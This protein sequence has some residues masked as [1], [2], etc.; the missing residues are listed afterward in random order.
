MEPLPEYVSDGVIFGSG[1]G[2]GGSAPF[3]PKPILIELEEACYIGSIIPDSLANL[4][5]GGRPAGRI[6]PKSGGGG[7]SSGN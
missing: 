6:D 3:S 5:T 7:S 4:I 2:T 1:G